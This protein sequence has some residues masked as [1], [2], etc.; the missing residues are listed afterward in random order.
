MLQST[1][2][3]RAKAK[4]FVEIED[5]HLCGHASRVHVRMFGPLSIELAGSVLE[6]PASRKVCGLL[7]YLAMSRRPVSRE[8]LC[9]LLWDNA[10]SDPRGELRWCLSKLRRLLGDAESHTLIA[11]G[12][13]IALRTAGWFV[14]ALEVS[15]AVDRGLVSFDIPALQSLSDLYRG[16]VLEGLVFERSPEFN[17]W[18]TTLRSRY[19]AIRVDL[20]I[21]LVERLPAESP[22]GL[23]ALETWAEIA[24][25]NNEA[26]T[27]LLTRLAERGRIDAGKRH[28]AAVERLYRAECLDFTPVRE[29]WR[30]L[31]KAGV[32]TA[33]AAPAERFGPC[34]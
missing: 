3:A 12:D 16:E 2:G 31:S 18:L 26:Q 19:S 33:A 14:D 6:L 21:M 7:A 30:D 29:A 22:Q 32:A 28:L 25:F 20:L 9:E 23:A 4:A 10:A 5:R 8:R 34:R 17:L 27:L 11:E 1:R 13:A 15:R 24:P